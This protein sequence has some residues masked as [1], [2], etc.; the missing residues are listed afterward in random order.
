[1]E[2]IDILNEIVKSFNEDYSAVEGEGV[3]CDPLHLRYNLHALI[4]FY[5]T[6]TLYKRC[7]VE[8]G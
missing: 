8:V 4:L 1:M 2:L 3:F 7:I 5:Q 6:S